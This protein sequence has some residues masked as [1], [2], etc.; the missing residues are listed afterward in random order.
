[1]VFPQNLTEV[2]NFR[3]LCFCTA[4]NSRQTLSNRLKIKPPQQILK[5]SP[6]GIFYAQLEN[7]VPFSEKLNLDANSAHSTLENPQ[8]RFRENELHFRIQHEKLPLDAWFQ[9]FL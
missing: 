9:Y 8:L 3:P 4:L 5:S 6:R 1:M 7:E 2:Q